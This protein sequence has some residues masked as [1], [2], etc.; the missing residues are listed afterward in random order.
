M[1]KAV[2]RPLWFLLAGAAALGSSGCRTHGNKEV[3]AVDDQSANEAAEAWRRLRTPDQLARAVER[4]PRG[5]P[6]ARVRAL[7]GE[8]L[9]ISRLADGGE[10]WLYIKS[11]PARGQRESLFVTFDLSGN[12]AGLERKPLD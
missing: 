8:P 4:I 10:A 12:L 7:L 11:D 6:S 9:S 3:A 5:T 1:R 2:T